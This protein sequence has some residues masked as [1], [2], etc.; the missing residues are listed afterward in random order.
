[1][2]RVTPKSY[3]RYYRKASDARGIPASY[4]PNS[5]RIRRS[6]RNETGDPQSFAV[7]SRCGSTSQPAIASFNQAIRK[8]GCRILPRIDGTLNRRFVLKGQIRRVKE[9]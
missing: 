2:S 1:M 6:D 3:P 8:I 5:A 9:R 4:A 7:E